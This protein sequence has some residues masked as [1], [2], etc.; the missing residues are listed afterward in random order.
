MYAR[1]ETTLRLCSLRALATFA[2]LLFAVAAH[3]QEAPRFQI[4]FPAS[5]HASPI[6]GRVYVVLATVRTPEP[7][8]QVG[9]F[10]SR[11]QFFGADVTQLAPAQPVTISTGTLGYPLADL[12]QLPPGDYYAQAVL[13]IYTEFHRSDGHVIWAHLD[14]GEGQ[15]FNRSPGNLYSPVSKIHLDPK[16]SAEFTLTLRDVIP[17]IP[18][19]ADT[20]WIKHLRIQSKLLSAFWGQ[21]I[22]LGA[23][24][25]LPHGYDSASQPY[26]VIYDQGHFGDSAPLDFTDPAVENGAEYGRGAEFSALVAQWA[27]SAHDRRHL[28]ASDAVFRRFLRRQFR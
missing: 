12:S 14:Q 24:V 4:F 9:G 23:T 3:A 27:S 16:G 1:H 6:T 20:A 7:R 21:P 17:P 5:V 10:D 11:T 18:Q 22:Y 28:S 15:Q 13:N 8:L 26:P 19:P 2:L 25:L